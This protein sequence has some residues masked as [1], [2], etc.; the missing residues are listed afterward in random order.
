MTTT[1]TRVKLLAQIK[2]DPMKALA[3]GEKL[4]V[5][6]LATLLIFYLLAIFG[7]TREILVG[8]AGSG[9][10]GFLAVTWKKMYYDNAFSKLD[11]PAE[12]ELTSVQNGLVKMGFCKN[13][14][15]GFSKNKNKFSIFHKCK[16]EIINIE[17]GKDTIR[18]CG[19]YEDLQN[20]YKMVC[21]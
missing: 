17:Y 14:S 8:A 11:L 7:L 18:L 9:T 15:G 1:L 10:L 13:G 21:S 2:Y 20:I 16:S 3:L 4:I 19:P 6:F 12:I 5:A